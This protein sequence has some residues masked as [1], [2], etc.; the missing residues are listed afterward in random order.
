MCKQRAKASIMLSY[1]LLTPP[2][3]FRIHFPLYRRKL[4]IRE[5]K[6]FS[7]CTAREEKNYELNWSLTTESTFPQSLSLST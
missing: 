6:V 7:H 2:Y 1:L 3:E 5:V 4:K